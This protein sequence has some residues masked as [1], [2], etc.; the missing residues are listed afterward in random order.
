MVN[1]VDKNIPTE[2][3]I[4][5]GAQKNIKW[6]A[7]IGISNTGYMPPTIGAGKVF[8]ASNNTDPRDPKIKGDKAILKCFRE[9][10]GQFLWQIVHEMPSEE[11]FQGF[12]RK[13][14]LVSTPFLDNNRLYYVTPAAVVVCADTDGNVLWQYDM[15]KELKV[16]PCF[17]SMCSPLVAD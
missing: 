14:G 1:L 2:W 9:S 10:D 11:I 5:E 8:I 4:Q 3:S 13:D 17:C 15:I 16:Y 12:P 6:A 7:K